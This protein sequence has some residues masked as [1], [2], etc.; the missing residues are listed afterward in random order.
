MRGTH[1]PAFVLKALHTVLNRLMSLGSGDYVLRH[2]PNEDRLLLYRCQTPSVSD[3]GP[4]GALDLHALLARAGAVNLDL[5]PYV[6]ACWVSGG[7][8][9]IPY[10]F[11]PAGSS[12]QG[13]SGTTTTS[14]SPSSSSTGTGASSGAS[15]AAQ[16]PPAKYCHRFANTGMCENRHV[17]LAHDFFGNGPE[18][19]RRPCHVSL[20]PTPTSFSVPP[21]VTSARSCQCPYEHITADQLAQRASQPQR[22][23]GGFGPIRGGG[24]ANTRGRGRP[25]SRGG[26]PGRGGRAGGRHG[27][28]AR[29]DDNG[30]LPDD[31]RHIHEALAES[32]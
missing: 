13:G 22:G 26:A 16:G 23:R 12:S 31:L 7:R 8:D 4:S 32:P 21:R 28:G 11:A 18:L 3:V 29:S 10:T 25:W 1:R 15:G 6:P 9:Q 14:S 19:T 20:N 24:P 17:R 5:D 30:H 2:T 27:V